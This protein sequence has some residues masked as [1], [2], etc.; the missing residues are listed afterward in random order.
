[1]IYTDQPTALGSADR[2]EA[3]VWRDNPGWE[4]HVRVADPANAVTFRVMVTGASDLFADNFELESPDR[5]TLKVEG[6]T[7]TFDVLGESGPVGFDF[8]SC[9]ISS[10]KIA[11]FSGDLL[12]LPA[13][14][15]YVGIG[16][17]APDNPMPIGRS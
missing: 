6:N 15:I 4:W 5:G 9:F 8:N 13:S 16:N 14:D 2:P 17:T 12:G 7:A 11:V 10:M 3:Y 1:V